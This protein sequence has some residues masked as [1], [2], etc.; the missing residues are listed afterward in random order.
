MSRPTLNRSC[1][2]KK[3]MT[4]AEAD[5]FCVEDATLSKYRCKFCE[6]WHVGHKKGGRSS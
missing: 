5:R 2:R 1:K 4:E 6:H 3:V